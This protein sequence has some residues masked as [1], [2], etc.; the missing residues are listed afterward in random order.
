MEIPLKS[1]LLLVS[2]K[3]QRNLAKKLWPRLLYSSNSK[4]DCPVKSNSQLVLMETKAYI[5]V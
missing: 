2:Q 5:L 3:L 4:N 1:F